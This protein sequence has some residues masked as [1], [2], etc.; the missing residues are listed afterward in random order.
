M[1]RPW[2]LSRTGQGEGT[3]DHEEPSRERVAPMSTDMSSASLTGG[4]R[5]IKK[6]GEILVEE[7]LIS[8][9]QLEKALLN[10]AGPTSC[11]AES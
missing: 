6:L 2:S 10:R 3:D 5:K 7:G 8:R 4:T 9:E 1:G 11:W